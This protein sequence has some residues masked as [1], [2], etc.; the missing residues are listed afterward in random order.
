MCVFGW[1]D[2]WMDGFVFVLLMELC[3]DGWLGLVVGGCWGIFRGVGGAWGHGL[4]DVWGLNLGLKVE[5]RRFMVYDLWSVYL[6]I[7]GNCICDVMSTRIKFTC[8]VA[9]SSMNSMIQ[10]KPS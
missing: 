3:M 8:G 6:P 9:L 5:G 7:Y 4:Q 2:G 10:S 1:M